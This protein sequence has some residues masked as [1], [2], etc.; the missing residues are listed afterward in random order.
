M[1]LIWESVFTVFCYTSVEYCRCCGWPWQL[2]S[3]FILLFFSITWYLFWIWH[4]FVTSWFSKSQKV[5]LYFEEILQQF[6]ISYKTTKF[7]CTVLV[8]WRCITV[9]FSVSTEVVMEDNNIINFFFFFP[10]PLFKATKAIRNL[11]ALC[12]FKNTKCIALEIKI[13][14]TFWIRSS[15]SSA[16]GNVQI[17]VEERKY[18]NFSV[19]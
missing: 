6:F 13:S 3:L 5:S 7:K 11:R 2:W 4:C 16:F 19:A 1:S 10:N 14:W 8:V 17:R 9:I 18:C 12:F 15:L